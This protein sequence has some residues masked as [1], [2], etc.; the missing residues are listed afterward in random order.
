MSNAAILPVEPDDDDDARLAP[1]APPKPA[2]DVTAELYAFL[3]DLRRRCGGRFGVSK[4][5]TTRLMHEARLAGLIET[6][7]TVKGGDEARLTPR[8][9]QALAS[10]AG[11][12]L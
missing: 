3:D 11:A 2:W 6:R 10:G 5:A 9:L 1:P 4:V 12:A 7:Q 8:G